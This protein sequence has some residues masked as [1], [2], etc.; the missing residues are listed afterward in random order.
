MN[1]GGLKPKYLLLVDLQ[2]AYDSVDRQKLMD[3]LKKRCIGETDAHLVRVIESLHGHQVINIGQSTI[4][5]KY[6][7]IQGSVL[8]PVLFNVYLEEALKSSN[9]LWVGGLLAF[10]DDIAIFG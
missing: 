2:K 1:Q 5:P 6:G 9:P 7:V 4:K 3:M 10:A 8:A